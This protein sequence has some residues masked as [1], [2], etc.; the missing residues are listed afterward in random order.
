MTLK[1]IKQKHL[2]HA[3][4]NIKLKGFFMGHAN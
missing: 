3:M 2:R 1:I 4:C